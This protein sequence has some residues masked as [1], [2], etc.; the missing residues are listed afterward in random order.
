MKLG[1]RSELITAAS[2]AILGL[3]TAALLTAREARA[4][5]DGDWEAL[6][7]A[8]RATF[9][10]QRPGEIPSEIEQE[11]QDGR[12]VYE[13]EYRGRAGNADIT[14]AGDGALV[15]V[16]TKLKAKDLPEAVTHALDATYP[17]AKVTEAES[18]SLGYY[19]LDLRVAG[20][21]VEVVVQPDGKIGPNPEEDDADEPDDDED[22]E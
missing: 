11:T 3:A 21:K 14:V 20:K 17:G 22:G 9:E 15:M 13:A 8:V 12:E 7:E 18:V 1:N 10:A 2:F 4:A 19:E 5:A 6:P 16:K